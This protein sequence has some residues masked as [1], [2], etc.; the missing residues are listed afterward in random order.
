MVLLLIGG[1]ASFSFVKQK[2]KEPVGKEV[3]LSEQQSNKA[4]IN[5]VKNENNSGKL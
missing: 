4:R 5:K 3:S 1:F 2:L